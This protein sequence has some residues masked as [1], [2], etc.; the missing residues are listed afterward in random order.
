MSETTDMEAVTKEPV[1]E[2]AESA[3]KVVSE[4]ISTTESEQAVEESTEKA[5]EKPEEESQPMEVEETD[6][7]TKENETHEEKENDVKETE[8]EEEAEEEMQ[9]ASEGS[10]SPE[11]T[12]NGAKNDE[13]LLSE[14]NLDRESPE[15]WPEKIP[16]V[17]DFV[18][19]HA[20][21]GSSLPTWTKGLTQ[22][23]I[24]QMHELGAMSNSQLILEIKKLYDH[25]Y[26]IG[27][28]ESK[29]MSRGKL[30]QIFANSKK[31]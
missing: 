22:E 30:L 20:T 31:K 24:D 21:E 26:K 11:K 5:S 4:A 12:K 7:E 10:K 2:T 15:I 9:T 1:T 29:E 17:Q 8:E 18:Q 6:A 25:A 23:D 27:V 16:G 14:E 19:E 28:E 3:E 13:N